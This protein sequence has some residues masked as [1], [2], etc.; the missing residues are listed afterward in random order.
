MKPSHAYDHIERARN[1]G[2]Q[3]STLPPAASSVTWRLN[4][5]LIAVTTTLLGLSAASE[6]LRARAQ[7]LANVDREV[8]A[9]LS[10]GAKSLPSAVWNFDTAQI[11]QIIASEMD[12]PFVLA[13]EVANSDK[14][15][16]VV[17]RN[18]AGEIQPVPPGKPAE[19][20]RSIV[21]KYVDAG[22]TV[23]AATLSVHVSLDSVRKALLADL[24][25]TLLRAA[26]LLIVLVACLSFALTRMVFGPT[27]GLVRRAINNIGRDEV[28][29]TQRLPPTQYSEL[30]TVARGFNDFTDRLHGIVQQVKQSSDSVAFGSREIA[31]GIQDLAQ[32]THAQTDSVRTLAT[33]VTDLSQTVQQSTASAVEAS[34]MARAAESLVGE[35][36]AVMSQVD[37]GMA[38]ISDRSRRIAGIIEVI[39]T[40]AFQT[41]ILALNAAVESARAGEQGRGFA[42]VAAEVRALAQRSTAAAQEIKALISD[43]SAM[44]AKACEHTARAGQTMREIVDAARGVATTI[45]EISRV[46]E[47]QARQLNDISRTI[48][49]IEQTTLSNHSLVEE[50]SAAALSL[51]DQAETLLTITDMFKLHPAG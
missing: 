7:H 27:L 24:K 11:E 45:A 33:T 22:T 10:R 42:V 40:I 8:T 37:S 3:A 12:A 20:V 5:L 21:V 43:S 51:R 29:L 2:A 39:D 50:G 44:T 25:W 16:A 17:S 18:A 15:L 46:S 49:A 32:R 6:Y 23:D 30:N 26:G 31:Q 4:L 13:V 9:A 19:E 47:H 36:N 14:T 34:R 41:N 1:F 28:D 38:A 48:G 35:G